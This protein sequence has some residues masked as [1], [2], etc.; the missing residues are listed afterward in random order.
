MMPLHGNLALSIIPRPVVDTLEFQAVDAKR[1]CSRRNELR[2]RVTR[3]STCAPAISGSW[4][5]R[6]S[7]RL[8]ARLDNL[9]KTGQYVLPLGGGTGWRQDGELIGSRHG[10]LA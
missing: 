1:M 3:C 8:D 4:R 9:T 5:E 2:T 6:A 7:M 10:P